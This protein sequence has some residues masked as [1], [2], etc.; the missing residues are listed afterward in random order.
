MIVQKKAIQDALKIV[1]PLIQNSPIIPILDHVAFH[2]NSVFASN[3]SIFAAVKFAA[4]EFLTEAGSPKIQIA[5]PF[6][7]IQKIVDACD[8]EIRFDTDGVKLIVIS[9]QSRSVLTGERFSDFP[10]FPVLHGS[11][12]PIVIENDVIA[13]ACSHHTKFCDPSNDIRREFQGIYFNGSNIVAT[14]GHRVISYDADGE[15]CDPLLIPAKVFQVLSHMITDGSDVEFVGNRIK[16]ANGVISYTPIDAQFPDWKRIFP[17][18]RGHIEL[19]RNELI[20]AVRMAAATADVETHSIKIIGSGGVITVSAEDNAFGR[21]SETI[22]DGKISD[23]PENF[24]ISLN[25]KYLLQALNA[26]EDPEIILWF[27][28]TA[29]VIF[30]SP[31]WQGQVLIAQL[32]S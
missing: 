31:D 32:R 17:A 2:G 6:R 22:I 27:D 8:D 28:G 3:S 1:S 24:L 26:T 18:K 21:S 19:N 4:S 16:T 20:R 9:G 23:G 5:V 7:E 11:S 13:Y 29:P 12:T 10:A 30:T 25:S 14:D 15:L